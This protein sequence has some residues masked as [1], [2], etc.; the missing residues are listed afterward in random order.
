MKA[1]KNIKLITEQSIEE[2]QAVIF[3]QQIREIIN[4]NLLGPGIDVIDGGGAYLSAGFIDLHIHGCAGYDAMDEDDSALS[5]IAYHLVKT[6]VTAFLP[7]TMTMEVTRIKRALER[8]KKTMTN[9]AGYAQILGCNLEGPFINKEYKGAHDER[10]IIRP[11]YGLIRPYLDLIRLI[12]IAPEE[13]GSLNFIKEA[14]GSGVVV[15]IGHSSATFAEAVKG[16]EAGASH[17]THMFNAMT[18][19]HHRNPGVV[20]AAMLYDLTC[21]LIADNIHVEPAVQN[22]LLK[23]KGK[24]KIILITDAMRACLLEDGEYDL[25]GQKVYVARHQARLSNGKLAGSVLRMNEA[26]RNFMINTGVKMEDAV[27][28]ATINP[29]KLIGIEKKKGSIVPGKDADLV[30]F[31]QDLKVMMT[32]IGGEIV[33]TGIGNTDN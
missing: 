4:E 21:E 18:P 16:Y 29:A 28:M 9:S 10:Y 6:G 27:K 1:I 32:I 22:I 23:V 24:D 2:Q 12:T 31:D 8:I 11:N 5:S 7:T 19:L 20:G 25:G 14:A 13:E 3:D 17:I 15:S 26:I 33:Y 30:I